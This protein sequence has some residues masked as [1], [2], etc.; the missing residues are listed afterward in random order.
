MFRKL[1]NRAI[2]DGIYPIR[3]IVMRVSIPVLCGLFA[4]FSCT[5]AMAAKVYKWTD[6]KGITHFSEHPPLNTKTT[7]VKP[8]IAL[9]E[10]SESSAGAASST[11]SSK[12][13]SSLDVRAALKDPA[14]CASAKQNAE[15]LKTYSHIKVKEE[16]G[17]Y[18]YLTPDEQAQRLTEATKAAEESC[19]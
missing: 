17:E 2:V 8:Q 14:R 6:E 9:G 16:N 3:V 19:P 5:G 7:L 15:T 18:R 10:S 4:L 12:S 1:A 13:S 11:A